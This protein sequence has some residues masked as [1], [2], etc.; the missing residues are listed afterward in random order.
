MTTMMMIKLMKVAV[1]GETDADIR[2]SEMSDGVNDDS[3][4]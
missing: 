1:P 2:S 3:M 4:S